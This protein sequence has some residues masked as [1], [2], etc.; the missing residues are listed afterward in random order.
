V[1]KGFVRALL[2][3]VCLLLGVAAA[4]PGAAAQ[5]DTTQAPIQLSLGDSW[6]F[7][8]GAKMPSEG[9]YVPRLHEAL[10]E[11]L[12]CSG[13]GSDAA[14]AGCPQLQLLN[15]A[16]GGATTPTMVLDQFPRALSL[17]ESRNGNLDPGDDVE[18]VTLHI[19][20]NDVTNPIIAACIGGLTET[21][22]QVIQAEFAAY[23]SDLD[24]ALSALRD[25]AGDDAPIVIG[26]Y[27]NPIATCN[28]GGIPGAVQ[29]ADLVLE[30]GPGVPQGLHDI[31]REVA[32]RYDI[33]VAEVFGD[34]AP[35]DWVGGADCL[36]PDDSGYNKVKKAFLEVLGEVLGLA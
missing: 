32:A 14:E 21:C 13:A 3:S 36:H 15:L 20:G 31:M 6:A 29:L 18:L 5:S 25:A 7:G 24:G 33:Q 8:F 11:D 27:D 26:T 28:L 16:V 34:L 22:L 10:Q 35:Q 19:G 4:A 23:R 17:L 1:R 30:G 12:N 9:G 2:I